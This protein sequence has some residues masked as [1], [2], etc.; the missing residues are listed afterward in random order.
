MSVRNAFLTLGV[1]LLTPVVASGADVRAVQLLIGPSWMTQSYTYDGRDFFGPF[2]P[3]ESLLGPAGGI[4]IELGG[5]RPKSLTLRGEALYLRKGFRE[6]LTR[7][8]EEGVELGTFTWAP[9]AHFLS[10]PINLRWASQGVRSPGIHIQVGPTIDVLL[11]HDDSG[12]FD[13]MDRTTL[14]V[15]GEF[16]LDF[17]GFHAGLRYVT[18]LTNPYNRPSGTALASVKNHGVLVL[19]GWDLLPWLSA[20]DADERNSCEHSPAS[21]SARW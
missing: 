4:A 2:D 19:L 5:V 16:G 21:R 17:R 15:D 9:R 18:D 1:V 7:T 11:R 10:V 12:V 13:D 3:D 8:N 14:G 20:A 6:H